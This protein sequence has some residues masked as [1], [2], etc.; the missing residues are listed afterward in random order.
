MIR[1]V[2]SEVRRA[3]S[4]SAVGGRRLSNIRSPRISIQDI[5]RAELIEAAKVCIAE[6]GLSETTLRDVAQYARTTASSV[7]YHFHSKEE[8][9]LATIAATADELREHVERE[10]AAT[11][12]AVAKLEAVAKIAL[13]SSAAATVSWRLWLDIRA[14]AVRESFVRPI[15]V[16][17]YQT[18]L[19]FIRRI[20]QEGIEAGELPATD[21]GALATIV[22]STIDGIAFY[23]LIDRTAD[24]RRA[25][26]WCTISLR[27]LLSNLPRDALGP[28]IRIGRRAKD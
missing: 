20:I 1:I 16:E 9:I 13:E 11:E 28:G 18:W 15:Y 24:W 8:L 12:G 17:K 3:S 23:L 2:P 7:V 22:S 19:A 5:R 25:A 26:K 6:R 14:Q 27:A 4:L 10:V 21:A